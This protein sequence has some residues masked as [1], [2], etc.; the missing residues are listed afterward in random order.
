MA[1]Y[2]TSGNTLEATVQQVLINKG[3]S[4]IQYSEW[5]NNSDKYGEELL[6]THVP[7]QS[8]YNHNANTEFLLKSKKYN[9]EI[10]IECKWQQVSGSVDEKLPYLYLN[11]IEAMPEQKIIV[12]ID[13]KGWKHGSIEWLKESVHAK[14]YTNTTNNTKDIRVAN[15]S[16]FIEWANRFFR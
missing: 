12:V 7:F 9:I 5:K 6:L 1:I 10:R 4:M 2:T 15:L 16:E 3:F 8:I 14:K 11:C 13:G